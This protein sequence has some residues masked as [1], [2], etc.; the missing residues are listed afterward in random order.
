M[1]MKYEVVYSCGHTGT[2]QIYGSAKDRE[3]KLWW[4]ANRAICPEC[5]K[6]EAIKAAGDCDQVTMSYRQYKTEYAD[7]KTVPGTYDAAEKIITVL[8]PKKGA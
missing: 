3:R 5:T 6:A 2:E 1:A 7:C 4:Y 8:V